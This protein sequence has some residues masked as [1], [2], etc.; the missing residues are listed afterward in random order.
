[1]RYNNTLGVKPLENAKPALSI[2]PNPASQMLNIGITL[3]EA[4][5]VKTDICNAMGEVVISKTA[6]MAFGANKNTLDVGALS[7][8]IYFVRIKSGDHVSTQRFVKE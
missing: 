1:L 3:S 2:Y 6:N 8:G 7:N 5:E 4:G